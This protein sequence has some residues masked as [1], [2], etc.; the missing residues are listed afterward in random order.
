VRAT[1]YPYSSAATHITQRDPLGLI[2]IQKWRGISN[3]INWGEVLS[4]GENEKYIGLIHR[5][6]RTGQ[7]LGTD[8]FLS[9]IESYLGRKIRSLPVGRAKNNPK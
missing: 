1:E 4:R 5:H 3:G 8:S 9:K 2:N 6:L 7:P